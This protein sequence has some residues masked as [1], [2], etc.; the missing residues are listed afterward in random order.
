MPRKAYFS[1]PLPRVFAHRGLA[2]ETKLGGAAP[3][4]TLL[5]FA[6]A[7]ETGA[8]YL[9]TDVHASS[10]GIAVISHDPDLTRLTG[11]RSQVNE[12]T[13]DQLSR[14]NLGSDQ[15]FCSIGQAL[16]AFPAARFN[17]D[18]KSADA[19]Q[20]TVDAILAAQAEDRVLVTSFSE[21]RRKAAVRQLPGV[22]TSSGAVRFAVALIVGKLGITP[23]LRAALRGVDAVQVPQKAMGLTITTRRM[24][25]RLHDAGVEIHVWTINDAATMV[26]LLDLGVDGLVTDRADIAI[27]VVK[28]RF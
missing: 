12:F 5:A 1:P 16:D 14:M 27:A 26:E 18:I 20:P 13:F 4:N 19:V 10:D 9:E 23:L 21:R 11:N 6:T 24:I 22:A 15:T 17:I 7:M 28:N 8:L 3:E 25:G 2:I